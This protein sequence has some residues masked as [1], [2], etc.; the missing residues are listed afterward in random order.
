MGISL[1]P[2]FGLYVGY[3]Q[4]EGLSH[5][6]RE[7]LSLGEPELIEEFV[8]TDPKGFTVLKD[9]CSVAKDNKAILITPTFK[10][11]WNE[12]TALTILYESRVKLLVLDDPL[13]KDSN[14]NLQLL[15]GMKRQAFERIDTHSKRVREGLGRAKALG[16]KF[17]APINS[18]N[19]KLA[20]K[21]SSDKAKKFR[22]EIMPIINHLKEKGATTNQEIADALTALNVTTAM[23]K[24]KWFESTVRKIIKDHKG[25][26]K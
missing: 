26:E 14:T 5:L 21:G 23:G 10:G 24:S 19:L 12:L 18:T 11:L 6:I 9:A 16:K 1:K 7:A 25:E 13:W 22:N 8:E 17:G 20:Y 3:L 2:R 4:D 15:E